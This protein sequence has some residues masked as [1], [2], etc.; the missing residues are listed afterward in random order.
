MRQ[1]EG[2]SGWVVRLRNYNGKKVVHFMNSNLKPIPH[3]TAKDIS[4]SPVLDRIE[5]RVVNN[6][7]LFEVDTKQFDITQ[8]SLFSPELKNHSRPLRFYREGGKTLMAVDL[9]DIRIYAVA[10]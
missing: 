8:L 6:H 9:S 2:D 10:Q 7:L 5:S 1:I 3:P 4:Q